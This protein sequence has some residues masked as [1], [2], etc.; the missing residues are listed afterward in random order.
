[1]HKSSR[2]STFPVLPAYK[3]FC[4]FVVLCLP[5]ASDRSSTLMRWK[6][7]NPGTFANTHDC[8]NGSG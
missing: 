5:K 7:G 2:G 1:M 4:E 8:H 3:S 6:S